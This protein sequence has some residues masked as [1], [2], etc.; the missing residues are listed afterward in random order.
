LKPTLI[1]VVASVRAKTPAK[2]S[3][4]C[5]LSSELQYGAATFQNLCNSVFKSEPALY[6]TTT[7]HQNHRACCH[8]AHTHTHLHE[9]ESICN[10]TYPHF[11][12]ESA[13]H[14]PQ[15]NTSQ[16]KVATHT[17]DPHIGHKEEI[18]NARSQILSLHFVKALHFFVEGKQKPEQQHL[19]LGRLE[20][21]RS[22]PQPHP[23]VQLSVDNCFVTSP[24]KL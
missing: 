1:P 6:T 7:K 3:R 8:N 2:R 18:E 4:A 21:K 19:L 17:R 24:I 12:Q 23:S 22:G 14:D 20:D 13:H 15:S 16:L 11:S 10:K 5:T 9:L